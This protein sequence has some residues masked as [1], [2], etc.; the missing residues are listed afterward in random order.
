MTSDRNETRPA[1]TAAQVPTGTTSSAPL[2]TSRSIFRG[3]REAT[4]EHNGEVYRLRITSKDKLI[5]TK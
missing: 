3:G 5:L 1:D 2:L 4:I